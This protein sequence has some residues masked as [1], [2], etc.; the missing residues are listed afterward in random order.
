MARVHMQWLLR[1]LDPEKHPQVV[2]G[3]YRYV[4]RL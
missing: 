4:L 2:M 1:W 3:P